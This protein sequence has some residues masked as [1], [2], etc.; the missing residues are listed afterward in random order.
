MLKNYKQFKKKSYSKYSSDMSKICAQNV[1]LTELVLVA[2]VPILTQDCAP[3]Y[4]LH[5]AFQENLQ[6][7]DSE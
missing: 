1:I 5:E 3:K 4:N 2:I 7:F 6:K